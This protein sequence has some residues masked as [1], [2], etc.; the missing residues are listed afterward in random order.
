M[1]SPRV[2]HG[3]QKTLNY[4]TNS[5]T[6]EGEERDK[7][8]SEQQFKNSRHHPSLIEETGSWAPNLCRWDLSPTCVFAS[9]VPHCN[10]YFFSAAVWK[11]WIRNRYRIFLTMPVK[12]IIWLV[13]PE[14]NKSAETTV[15]AV[16]AASYPQ[17]LQCCWDVWMN[18]CCSNIL[19]I[20]QRFTA[21]CVWRMPLLPEGGLPTIYAV[22]R[23]VHVLR[24]SQTRIY[25]G[26]ISLKGFRFLSG[27]HK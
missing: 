20:T 21:R 8:A 25:W 1:K 5:L 7:D 14:L 26:T 15:P 9:L 22:Y 17:A 6:N 10:C 11:Y 16:T 23:S 3:E 27:H 24:P 12:S 2:L 4:D 13:L 18:L 19:Y